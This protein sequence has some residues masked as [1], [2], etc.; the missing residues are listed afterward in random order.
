MLVRQDAR[1]PGCNA[2]FPTKPS[3]SISLCR[4][5]MHRIQKVMMFQKTIRA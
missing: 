5:Q 1:L 4:D 2:V 3:I